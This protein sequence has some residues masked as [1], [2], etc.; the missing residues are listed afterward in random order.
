M[1]ERKRKRKSQQGRATFMSSLFSLLSTSSEQ[2]ECKRTEIQV[3]G[4]LSALSLLLHDHGRRL[5][6]GTVTIATAAAP[7]P[8]RARHVR[9]AWMTS[10]MGRC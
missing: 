10:S 4:L 7:A 2:S 5:S 9:P 3:H 8:S 6:V 1:R